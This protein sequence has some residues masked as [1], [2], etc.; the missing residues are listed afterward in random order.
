MNRCLQEEGP[1]STQ[2]VPTPQDWG[3]A[4]GRGLGSIQYSGL[5]TYSEGAVREVADLVRSSNQLGGGDAEGR[6]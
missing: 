3:A 6:G 1:G 2:D 5:K 4:Q